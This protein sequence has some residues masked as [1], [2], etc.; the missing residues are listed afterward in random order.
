MSSAQV[1]QIM[2]NAPQI[3]VRSGG[4]VYVYNTTQ[5]S[6]PATI[7]FNDKRKV[8]EVDIPS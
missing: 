3:S 7:K 5:S 8:V 4:S 1:M 6:E 2:R